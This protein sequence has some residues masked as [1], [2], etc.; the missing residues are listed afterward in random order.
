MNNLLSRRATLG[1][2][3]AVV[4]SPAL[5]AP[6][7]TVILEHARGQAA[8]P[9][10]PQRV[11]VYD[12]GALDTLHTLG[13]PIA[14]GA[15]AQMPDYLTDYVARYTPAGSLF[16]PDYDALS[17][18]QPDLIIVGGRSAARYDTLSRI[19]PTLDL[20]V[21]GGHMLQDIARNITTL[22]TLFGKADQGQVLVSQIRQ[23]VD[24]LRKLAGQAEPGLLLMGFN[25][26]IAPQAPGARF[27]FLF[28]VF[29]ARS[30]IGAQDI[31]ARGTPYTFD[32]VA[33]LNPAWIYVIDRNTATGSAAGGGAVLASQK[34]FDNP[35]VK[36]TV[37]GRKGQVVFLDPKGWYLMGSAGP[38][39]LLGNM[40][41][42]RAA[43]EAATRG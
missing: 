26:R 43:Y 23:Q 27:G 21:R 11:V 32:D 28:D 34:V 36:G 30:A 5:S 20:S 24:G 3:V 25:E 39:A 19:A 6:A 18:I 10:R 41:Q 35:Q 9:T 22:S 15:R 16:V 14:G 17:R 4:C 13:V 29:G 42:L 33:R 12:V 7:G 37:A 38:T 40:A 1:A 31:P 2:I 8:V